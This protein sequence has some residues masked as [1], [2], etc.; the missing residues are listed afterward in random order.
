MLHKLI[1]ALVHAMICFRQACVECL[2]FIDASRLN[3]CKCED[4]KDLFACSLTRTMR[5]AT[6]DDRAV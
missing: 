1:K 3:V 4:V 5:R 6:C 2:L